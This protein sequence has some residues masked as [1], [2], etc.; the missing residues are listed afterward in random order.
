[1]CV[2]IVA[3]NSKIDKKT[4]KKAWQEN[5]DGF[6][7]AWRGNGEVH[8][9]K[10]IMSLKEA[11]Q[12]YYSRE[13]PLPHILHFR[14][15]SVGEVCPELTH[16]FELGWNTEL[17]GHTKRGVV[18]QNGT[19]REALKHIITVALVRKRELPTGKWSDARALGILIKELGV[20]VLNFLDAGKVAVFTP[21]KLYLHGEFKEYK[22]NLFSNLYWQYGYN[23]RYTPYWQYDYN[24]DRTKQSKNNAKKDIEDD[25]NDILETD[26]PIGF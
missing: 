9:K 18:F 12:F 6:G 11:M 3:Q 2:L 7:M 16:P 10:G 24:K 13:F 4:F 20:N 17:E 26:E 15:A 19:D 8:Y 21:D 22:G 14:I 1:M 23:Y 5:P 25:N